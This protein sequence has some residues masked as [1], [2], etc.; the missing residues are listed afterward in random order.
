[1]ES[2]P[3]DRRYT[4]G[5]SHP[6]RRRPV[7]RQRGGIRRLLAFQTVV[8][9]IL[10]CIIMIANSIGISAAGFLTRQVRY[11]LSRDVEL[12][13]IYA[14]MKTTVSDIRNSII[15][16]G[17][18]GNENRQAMEGDDLIEN[19][20]GT[21]TALSDGQ[22]DPYGTDVYIDTAGNTGTSGNAGEPENAD[23]AGQTA[24]AQDSGELPGGEQDDHLHTQGLYPETSVLAASSGPVDAYTSARPGAFGMIG[25]VTGRIVTPFGEI[26]GPGGV[27]RIHNGIDISVEYTSGVKAVMDGIVTDSGSMPGY[28]N[29][30]RLN[31]ENGITTVYGN[32]SSITAK[33]NDRVE[34]GNVIAMVGEDSMTGG[35]HLHFEVWNGNGPVDPLEYILFD[36][37]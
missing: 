9:I 1:M 2:Y 16:D 18:K 33:I 30:I 26:M 6:Y 32:C 14:F 7:I 12:K 11:V 10:F 17:S 27:I 8:S 29:F 19:T 36:A 20:D 25:P 22:T 24:P 23:T 21:V 34:K 28:G 3:T 31:H 15:P 37:G 4:A 13:N 35:S 5:R